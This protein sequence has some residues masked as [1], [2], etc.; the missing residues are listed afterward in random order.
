[1][2]GIDGYAHALFT[3]HPERAAANGNGHAGGALCGSG[4]LVVSR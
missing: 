4:G 1:V 3:P 2:F